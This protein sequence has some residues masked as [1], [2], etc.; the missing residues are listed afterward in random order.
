MK[1][2]RPIS[3]VLLCF[4][5]VPSVALGQ[6]KKPGDLIWEFETG[7]DVISAPAL[8]DNGYIYFGSYDNKVYA[9]NST[10]GEKIWDYDTGMPVT[11]TP[12]IGA[13]ST[14]YIGAL[15]NRLYAF[16]GKHGNVKWS[17][18]TEGQV[19][20]SPA[21]SGDGHLVF[22]SSDNYIYCLKE[23]GELNWKF[24]TGGMVRS[25][26]AIIEDTVIVPSW[27]K[28]V[29]AFDIISGENLWT[30]ENRD[31]ICWHP[32]VGASL[33]VYLAASQNKLIVLGKNGDRKWSANTTKT[34]QTTPV[35]VDSG[36]VVFAG[37]SLFNS[38]TGEKVDQLLTA[39]EFYT[40]TLTADETI[41]FSLSNYLKAFNLKT[42]KVIWEF[43]TNGSIEGSP[44]IDDQGVVYFGSR[45]NKFYAVQGTAPLAKTP[46]PT[47]G[48]NNKRTKVAT[49]D[50]KEPPTISKHPEAKEVIEG[51]LVSFKIVIS[52]SNP[53]NIDW[54]KDGK[55]IFG[56]SHSPKYEIVNV[57]QSHSG[58]YSALITNA[59]GVA[60]S[61]SAKLSVSKP[62]P[63]EISIHSWSIQNPD[64]FNFTAKGPNNA[65]FQLQNHEGED[66]VDLLTLNFGDSGELNVS[67]PIIKTD[68]T[69]YR[70]YRLKLLQ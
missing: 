45:D 39:A 41:Y 16:G 65:A 7:E 37:N 15:S 13:N 9:L 26:G 53:M 23:N 3:L 20:T 35:F 36:N 10:T 67:L 5:F 49:V 6:E 14:V 17:F 40:P 69:N 43:E 38:K 19:R 2:I 8:G 48:Q 47:F 46:W 1:L 56:P 25:S 34:M 27:D 21:I 52:G 66:W 63:P 32:A 28:N 24:K 68:N 4:A 44:A 58:T 22:G 59:H 64:T 60:F 61:Q 50:K 62:V 70:I 57:Q 51:D 30:V 12:A 33:N 55:K 42:Q 54:F 29:Y 11:S 31:N 18:K